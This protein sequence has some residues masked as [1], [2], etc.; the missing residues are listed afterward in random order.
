[1]DA[2]FLDLNGTISDDEAI[3]WEIYRALFA[4]S[5]AIVTEH[6]YRTQLV[7]QSDDEIFKR[8]LGPG[9]GTAEL[10]TERV[11]RYVAAVAD[12]ATVPASARAAVALAASVVPVV[13]VTSAWRHEADV[14]LE[15]SGL[16]ALVTLVV[17]ADDV[18]N[19]KPDP[20]PYRL[21]CRGLEVDPARAFAVE[22]TASGIRSARSAGVR[23]AAV[24]TT[25]PRQQLE[26]AD[27]LFDRLDSEAVATLLGL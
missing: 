25:M 23:C 26:E 27:L 20:E 12:G 8:V 6:E 15:A 4:E 16:N 22:D 17:S 18:A 1:V 2:L 3:L 19:L 13:V 10:V 9:V 11:R 24:T 14:V 21:A 5:G 7:G